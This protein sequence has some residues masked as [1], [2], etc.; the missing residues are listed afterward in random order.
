MKRLFSA[1]LSVVL[2][3]AL[4]VGCTNGADSAANANAANEK[5]DRETDFLIVGY[6]LAGEAAAL[7]ASDID[8]NANILV[9][10]KMPENLAGGNSIA[11]GQ[12]F[13][14]PSEDG[15]EG[16]KEYS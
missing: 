6:G 9:L 14:V 3:A 1:F 8:P 15:V 11:S 13:I 4:L 5:W 16:F 7:E 10:E 2:V 12:T